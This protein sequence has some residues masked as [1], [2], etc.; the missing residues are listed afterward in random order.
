M[1]DW[2]NANP[3]PAAPI[4]GGFRGRARGFR[5]RGRGR[6]GGASSSSRHFGMVS[7][8]QLRYQPYRPRSGVADKPPASAAYGHALGFVTSAKLD[9]LEKQHAAYKDFSKVLNT[10]PA[11]T[12]SLDGGDQNR[13]LI[14]RLGILYN[15]VINHLAPDDPHIING[16]IN[17]HDLGVWLARIRTDPSFDKAIVKEWIE[18]LETHIKQGEVKLEFAKLCG[19]L[20]TDWLESGDAVTV[21]SDVSGPLSEQSG[22]NDDVRQEGRQEMHE[23]L[24]RLRSIIFE[25]PDIDTGALEA[26]LDSVFS[27]KSSTA[28]LQAMR[29]GMATFGRSLRDRTITADDMRW[30]VE[31]LLAS[32][33]MRPDKRAALREFT[34]NQTVLEEVANVINM[35]LRAL[36]SWKWSSEGIVVDMRRYLHGKYRAFTDPDILDALFLQ[37]VGI[38]WGMK[39]K[40]DARDVF[41]SDAWKVA[42]SGDGLASLGSDIVAFGGNTISGHRKEYRATHF[43]AGHLPDNVNPRAFYDEPADA[44]GDDAS[45]T[46]DATVEVKQQLL[47]IMSAECCLNLSLHGSHTIVRTDMNWFGPSLPHESILA[48]LRFFGVPQDWL[49]FFRTFLRMPVR[50]SGESQVQTRVRG[51]PISYALSGFFGEAVLFGMDFAVNQRAHGL[52]LYRIHDDIWLWDPNAR[53]CALGW[54]EM[55]IYASRVGLTFNASKTGSASVRARLGTEDTPEADDGRL[56]RGDIHWGFLKFDLDE[57][58]FVIDQEQVNEHINE[59]RRQLGNTKS[60][61]GWIAVYNK[62]M[63][64]F[65]RNFGGRPAECFGKQHVVD[66]SRTLVRIQQEVITGSPQGGENSGGGA[67][68]VIEHLEKELAARYGVRDLPR[69]YFYFSLSSGGLALRDPLVDIL[70]MGER[71][72]ENMVAPIED[73]LR[74]EQEVFEKKKIAWE[75]QKRAEAAVALAQAPPGSPPLPPPVYMPFESYCEIDSPNIHAVYAWLAAVNKPRAANIPPAIQAAM[76]ARERRNAYSTKE[77]YKGWVVEAYGRDVVRRF[78]GLEIV[79]PRMIPIGLVHLY[80]TSRISITVKLLFLEP[81]VYCFRLMEEECKFIEVTI[82]RIEDE[83]VALHLKKALLRRRLNASRART[84]VLPPEI[85]TK[86]FEDVGGSWKKNRRVGGLRDPPPGIESQLAL[87]TITSLSV[88]GFFFF[89]HG[90]RILSH[91]PNLVTFTWSFRN[92]STPHHAYPDVTTTITLPHLKYINLVNYERRWCSLDADI[93][94]HL[95]LPSMDEMIW[96]SSLALATRDIW[97]P[98]F[99]SMPA[100]RMLTCYH[101]EGTLELLRCLPSLEVL[102]VTHG[103]LSLGPLF[104]FMTS[105][106]WEET[107]GVVPHLKEFTICVSEIGKPWD[108]KFPVLDA[109]IQML[110]SRRWKR[111]HQESF[112]RLI[113]DGL[114]LVMMEAESFPVQFG[115]E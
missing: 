101:S 3:W 29:E 48:I 112:R 55:N 90:L 63:A 10:G 5:G 24:A 33:L 111:N 58:R 41:H 18:A 56:P 21:R 9:E 67:S 34:D 70:V 84:K 15:S 115:V 57:A 108:S 39:F 46:A 94:R 36:G 51:T 1:S 69:G 86:I 40:Q 8:P 23:Q 26:Y 76:N 31:S 100:L 105:L 91:C 59:L 38:M 110:E 78:G 92:Y 81:P 17:I 14:D 4:R 11:P 54:Q 16:N 47:N 25:R 98:F 85:L 45:S 27:S 22:E 114:K 80:K 73:A 107:A 19:R 60:V 52:F 93:A 89:C 68:D 72:V 106:A 32:D 88:D 95:H 43:L 87:Q 75:A 103:T 62:Y 53:R 66:V 83:I 13:V 7:E 104:T 61:L 50:F 109:M 42:F 71:M 35:R 82:T 64:F 49:E 28:I 2:S 77:S 113:R 74:Q 102:E 30:T 65:V 44:A 79:D 37:W 12:D 20:Y 96:R 97:A 6:G 99:S